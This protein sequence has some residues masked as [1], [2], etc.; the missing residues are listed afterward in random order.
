MPRGESTAGVEVQGASA[1]LFSAPAAG[2]FGRMENFDPK[3]EEWLTYVESLE[4]F[5][6]VNNVPNEKKAASLLIL[7]GGKMYSLLKSLTTPTKQTE[8]SFTE[9][10]EVMTS[11]GPTFTPEPIVIAETY[12]FH[13]CN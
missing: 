11:Y 13:K 3:V 5:F 9:I 8:L 7:I 6:V 12:K 4:M 1:A 10:V 2:Y